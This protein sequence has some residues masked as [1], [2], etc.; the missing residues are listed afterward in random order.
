M[1]NKKIFLIIATLVVLLA[2][3]CKSIDYRAAYGY[4]GFDSDGVKTVKQSKKTV[5]NNASIFKTYDDEF[6]YDEDGNVIKHV[7]TQYFDDGERFNEYVVVYQKIGGYVLPKSSSLNG[8]VYLEVEYDLLPVDNEGEIPEHTSVPVFYRQIKQGLFY[9]DTYSKWTIDLGNFDMPFR[10]D[11]RF[12]EN[13]NSFDIYRG[14]DSD[15]VLTAGWDNIVLKKFDY[16]RDKFYEGL[17]V[18]ADRFTAN[19]ISRFLSEKNNTSFAFDWDVVA[20]KIIQTEIRCIETFED[21]TMDFRVER[22]FDSSARVT[23][24]RWTVTDDTQSSEEPI[25]L[26]TQELTY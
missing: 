9:A 23:E 14:F 5:L 22:K 24:E 12:V 15:S 3:G 20:D 26:F 6:V 18:T 25:I 2:A 16:S 13:E 8:V 17:A 10:I 11:G 1:K 4:V 19:R 7:Q 21:I